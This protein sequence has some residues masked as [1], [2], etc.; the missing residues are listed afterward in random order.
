MS[1]G[2]KRKNGTLK[3]RKEVR[4]WLP[5][6]S[7]T[8]RAFWRLWRCLEA[9]N[10]RALLDSTTHSTIIKLRLN[11]EI[12]K[13]SKR[14]F[15]ID[16][17]TYQK[18]KLCFIFLKSASSF[19]VKAFNYSPLFSLVSSGK[20]VLCNS[21]KIV[22]KSIFLKI[23]DLNSSELFQIIIIPFQI[24][25]MNTQKDNTYDW[26]VKLLIIG[27]SGVGKTNILLRFCDNNFIPSHLTTIGRFSI[28]I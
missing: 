22:R 15:Q 5:F 19:L 1:Q 18:G 24:S 11:D 25:S 26:L 2:V 12:R 17:W 23:Y 28:R 8:G 7:R 9:G 20:A 27:D 10:L 3:K 13:S 4:V 16:Y 6:L 14:A 21:N